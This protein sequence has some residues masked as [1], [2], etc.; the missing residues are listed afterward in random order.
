[1]QIGSCDSDGLKT[2]TDWGEVWIKDHIS[3]AL[4]GVVFNRAGDFSGVVM[5]I[6]DDIYQSSGGSDSDVAFYYQPLG[7][8]GTVVVPP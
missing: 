8:L 6:P 5:M 2:Q 3:D 1:M 7:L 4:T